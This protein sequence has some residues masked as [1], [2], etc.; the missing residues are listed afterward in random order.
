VLK[1]AGA[2]FVMAAGLTLRPGR[3]KEFFLGALRQAYP[4]LV[5]SYHE[6]YAEQRASGAATRRYRDQLA[7]RILNAFRG[8]GVP[9]LLPHRLYRGRLP[10]YD[11]VHL[12][13]QHMGELYAA[14]GVS[15]QELKKAQAGYTQWLLER[16]RAFNRKRSRRQEELEEETRAELN[17]D[18]PEAL[19]G[20]RKLA[21][22][23]RSATAAGKL[24]DYTTLSLTDTPTAA[25]I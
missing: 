17:R 23:L 1:E 14:R 24:L 6:I 11:E 7:E 4:G 8:S 15:I 25:T 20:N 13:L 3:Q 2:A 18:E 12:L 22:F 9:F 5:P 10:L 21:G 16:K 19:M